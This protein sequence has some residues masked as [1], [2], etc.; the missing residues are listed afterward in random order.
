MKTE[1]RYGM[2]VYVTDGVHEFY[3]KVTS[4]STLGRFTVAML[5]EG[6]SAALVRQ[7]HYDGTLVRRRGRGALSKLRAE[8]IS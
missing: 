5:S 1:A 6:M 4:V 2:D 7:F 3:G 8:L